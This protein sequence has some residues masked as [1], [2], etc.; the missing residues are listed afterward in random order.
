MWLL[1]IMRRFTGH[2]C[3][4]YH[5]GSGRAADLVPSGRVSGHMRGWRAAS[6]RHVAGVALENPT[7]QDIHQCLGLLSQS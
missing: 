5:A 7:G 6:V 2:V 1:I 3:Y 4:G